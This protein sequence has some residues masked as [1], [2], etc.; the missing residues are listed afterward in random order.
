MEITL[1]DGIITIDDIIQNSESDFIKDE[2][3][4][5][6]HFTNGYGL[7]IPYDIP[8]SMSTIEIFTNLSSDFVRADDPFAGGKFTI[9]HSPY[10]D[11]HSVKFF[12]DGGGHKLLLISNTVET[13]MALRLCLPTIIQ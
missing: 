5:K 2:L 4:S 3:K 7:F 1:L 9:I 12:L 11:F 8:I 6:L 13:L 10:G